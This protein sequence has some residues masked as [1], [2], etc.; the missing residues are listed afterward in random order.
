[1]SE[2][3]GGDV[4]IRA[5]D[6]GPNGPGGNIDLV[7]VTIKAGDGG[8]VYSPPMQAI[9]EPPPKPKHSIWFHP[10]TK[11]ILY[12]VGVLVAGALVRYFNLR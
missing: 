3:N 11:T 2:S 5:G 4:N 10:I 6:G 7:G 12:I 8:T 1:M 9:A